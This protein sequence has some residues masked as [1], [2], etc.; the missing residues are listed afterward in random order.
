MVKLKRK[1]PI[2]LVVLSLFSLSCKANHVYQAK[3]DEDDDV[4]ARTCKKSQTILLAKKA[5]ITS[6]TRVACLKLFKY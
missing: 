2:I 1:T 3:Y 4:S 5:A 6:L